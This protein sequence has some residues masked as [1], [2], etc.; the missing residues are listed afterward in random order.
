MH[1][2]RIKFGL[3]IGYA[4]SP[5]GADHVHNIHDTAYDEETGH[6]RALGILEPLPYNDLSPAK[7]RLTKYH[8]DWSVFYNCVGVCLFLPYDL[9]QMRDIVNGCTG[10]DTSIWELMKVGERAFNMA[11]AFN[12]REG[13][14]V[15]NN[16]HLPRWA[17]PFASGPKKGVAVHNEDMREALRLYY[18]MRGWDEETAIPTAAKLHELGIGWVAEELNRR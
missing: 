17:M 14:T 3:G 7:V 8:I 12:I 15:A 10:W 18:A 6:M 13:F 2:P 1:E 5:T 9:H 4:T 16:V 11:T